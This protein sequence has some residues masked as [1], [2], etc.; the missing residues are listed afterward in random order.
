ME[1]RGYLVLEDGSVFEG[2]SFGEKVS[3]EAPAGTVHY[4]I[5]AIG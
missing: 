1:E 2:Y 5:V 3:V 4:E